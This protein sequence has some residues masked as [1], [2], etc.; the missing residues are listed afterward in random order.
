MII[1]ILTLFPDMFNGPFATSMLKKAQDDGLVKIN[2][3]NLRD[4]ANDKHKTVDDKPFGGGPGMILK[5][6]VID[7][8]LKKLKIK[9]VTQNQLIKR[10]IILL[11]AK[12]NK[13]TQQKGQ[14][15]SKMEHLI[16]ISGH[17]EGVDERVNEHLVDEEISIGDYILTG[18]EIPVMVMV[19]NI[20]RLIPGLLNPESLLN[21]S[22]TLSTNYKLPTTNVEFPQYTRPE[23]YKGWKVPQVLLSG[24]HKEI[25]KWKATNS[26]RSA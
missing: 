2:I 26:T 13:Y 20:V 18:G 5:V 11:S 19:D 17:Y 15:L 7:R 24:N 8:A 1:D 25:E 21:E 10:Q 14:D 4:W 22:F 16:L 23:N 3:H 12:G 9:H 6:D